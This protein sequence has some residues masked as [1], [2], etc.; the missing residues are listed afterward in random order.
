MALV[1]GVKVDGRF[2]IEDTQVRVVDLKDY[3]YAKLELNG[4]QFEITDR[5]AVEIYPK[6]FVSCGLPSADLQRQHKE[7]MEWAEQEESDRKRKVVDGELTPEQFDALP[8]IEEP[9]NLLPRLIIEA[10][11]SITILRGELYKAF[12]E[13]RVGK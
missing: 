7:F 2:Y 5:E 4:K 11:R 12:D 8:R 13:S 10:P 1:L 9:Y 6:V 3:H